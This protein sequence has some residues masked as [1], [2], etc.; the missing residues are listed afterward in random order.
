[1]S[2]YIK[3]KLFFNNLHFA[4][5]ICWIFGFPLFLFVFVRRIF[6]MNVFFKNYY[7]PT[8]FGSRN[9]RF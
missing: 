6:Y 7:F 2:E 9:R 1:M 3:K 8:G 5:V 4:L